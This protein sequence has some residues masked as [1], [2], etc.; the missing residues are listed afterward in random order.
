MV[1]PGLE[2]RQAAAK[3][4]A[5][6]VDKK[7]PL[8]GLLDP[9]GGNPAFRN[10]EPADQ[11]LVRA[12]L[13]SALRQLPVIEA[14]LARLVNRPLPGGARALSH[15]L[16][17]GAAQILYLDTPD[18][19]AVDLAV[20]QASRDPRNRRY[21]ALVNA[22]LRRLIRE[23]SGLLPQMEAKTVNAPPW[24]YE[25]LQEA[26]G[27]DA[28]KILAAQALAPPIDITVKSDPRGWAERLGGIFLPT[29]SVR[30]RPFEG[31][32]T[33]LPGFAE[34]EW[35]V[36]DAAASIP[37][38]LFG[39]LAGVRVADLCAAPGGKTAQLVAA[40]ARVTAVD[41][42]RNRLRRLAENLDRL[43]LEAEI[44]QT[45][46]LKWR[47]DEAFDAVLLDAPCSSTGTV[48]RHPDIPW[49][50]S[51]ADIDKL[52]ELQERMLRHAVTLIRPGGMVVFSNC[53]LDPREGENMVERVLSSLP[54]IS[55]K[56]VETIGLQGLEFAI[57][58]SG[59]VRTHPAML[60]CETPQLSGM[61]GFF[62]SVLMRM[63]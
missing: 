46:L 11:A 35:W 53:S 1:K 54:E 24:F 14:M 15:V 44:V 16:T 30:L 32:I 29:G 63:G 9:S 43:K 10:L 27:A 55:R 50:K 7:T 60:E 25:R 12:I 4:L 5:A 40:G 62:A 33:Q 26:Y 20:E 2:A 8:D 21:T 22:V 38:Q 13:L 23:K 57:T 41:L 58:A 3:L 42:S 49:T 56:P 52:S 18:H 59:D 48:R 19:A 28:D 39:N 61:D 37:A 36:Q 17:V 6:V 51:P 31:P 47:P 45:D 34:G